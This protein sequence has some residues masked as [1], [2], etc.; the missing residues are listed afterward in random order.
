MLFLPELY[1]DRER[2]RERA[3]IVQYAAQHGVAKTVRKFE[4][5]YPGI[6]QQSVSYFKWKYE[7]KRTNPS[8]LLSEIET[9]KRGHPSLLPYKLMKRSINIIK[10]LRLKAAPVSYIGMSAVERE[11]EREV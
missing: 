8:V 10:A 5:K 9:K 3:E 6:K 7:L 11:R 1:K 4:I 2:E